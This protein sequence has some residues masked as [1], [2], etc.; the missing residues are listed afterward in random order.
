MHTF[1]SYADQTGTYPMYLLYTAMLQNC[2]RPVNG[3]KFERLLWIGT[4][5]SKLKCV[6]YVRIK[7]A[8]GV[9]DITKRHRPNQGS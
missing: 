8:I 7:V 1:N 3:R 6:V 4:C 9:E 5:S 2:V